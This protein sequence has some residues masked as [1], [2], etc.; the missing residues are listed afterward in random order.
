VIIT[1]GAAV[2]SSVRVVPASLIGVA[3]MTD[4]RT[5][6]ELFDIGPMV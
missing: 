1:R 5:S 3:A 2:M 4:S 6:V